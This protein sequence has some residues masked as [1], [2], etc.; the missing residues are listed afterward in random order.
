MQSLIK[1][2]QSGDESSSRPTA[3]TE[4]TVQTATG[5]IVVAREGDPRKPAIVTYHDLALNYLSNFSVRK[6]LLQPRFRVEIWICVQSSS[7]LPSIM[8]P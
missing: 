5:P 2:F 7:S 3:A 8:L 4:E 1:I 6:K